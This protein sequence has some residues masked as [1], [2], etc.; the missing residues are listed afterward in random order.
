MQAIS[1]PGCIS[2]HLVRS[3]GYGPD[4]LSPRSGSR[5][6]RALTTLGAGNIQLKE[7]FGDKIDSDNTSTRS[8]EIPPT[9]LSS[10]T[11]TA[12][13]VFPSIEKSVIDKQ[14]EPL[15]QSEKPVSPTVE[16]PGQPSVNL[17]TAS[18]K[19]PPIQTSTTPTRSSSLRQTEY[20]DSSDEDDPTL[21]GQVPSPT[22][23]LEDGTLD[24]TLD[25]MEFPGEELKDNVVTFEGR[26]PVTGT[27]G[28]P[29]FRY[30][31][32][33]CVVGSLSHG[34]VLIY[35]FVISSREVRVFRSHGKES[36][37][38]SISHTVFYPSYHQASQIF[39]YHPFRSK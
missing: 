10:E 7:A 25:D 28:M 38:I 33:K 17:S 4:S 9:P 1:Q 31:Y 24:E 6:N 16:M 14:T 36:F 18:V 39:S 27:T 32:M 22:A 37:H 13:I 21:P 35:P 34:P 29:S 26:V 3:D 20:A 19:I 30:K 2:V 23:S 15:C 11:R 5:K 12:A 8:E